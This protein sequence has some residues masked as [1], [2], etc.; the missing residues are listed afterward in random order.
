MSNETVRKTFCHQQL[1]LYVVVLLIQGGWVFI[2]KVYVMLYCDI[3]THHDIVYLLDV[4]LG[5]WI[6][7]PAGN[8]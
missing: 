1:N 8:V 6:N 4:Q 3:D 2:K 5:I 7:S